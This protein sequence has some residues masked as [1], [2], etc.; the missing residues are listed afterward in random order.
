MARTTV[1]RSEESR[2]LNS[3][4]QD[5]EYRE[6][7]LL[8]IPES[9]E[10]RFIDQGLKLRWIRILSRNQDD[11]RNVG[12]RQAEGKSFIPSFGGSKQDAAPATTTVVDVQAAA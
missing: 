11:Y 10:N 8:D 5:Y 3:R 9:V 7:N 12:K 4:E 1:S 6:P 2:E